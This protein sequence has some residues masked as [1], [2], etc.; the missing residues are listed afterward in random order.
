MT[1]AAIDFGTCWATPTGDLS[2]PASM[3]SG[4]QAVAQAVLRRWSATR[5]RLIDDPNYGE[6]VTDMIGDD[7]GPSDLAYAQQKLSAEAQKDE[8][9]LACVVA[10]ALS[11][12]GLLTVSAKITTAAGPFTMVVA[13]SAATV[14]LLLVSP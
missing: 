7:M 4:F 6:N 5:G 13:A 12:V 2:M 11:G 1:Q 10:L 3:A 9:V 14:Q 8:R